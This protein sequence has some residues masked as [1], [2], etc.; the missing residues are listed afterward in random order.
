MRQYIA[1]ALTLGIVWCFVNGELSILNFIVGSFLG[2]LTMVSLNRLYSL[3]KDTSLRNIILRIPKLAT[4]I[5]ILM[6]EIIKASVLMAKIILG[7]RLD[8]K[9]GIMAVPIR[10]SKDASITAIANT[11]SLTPGTITIDVSDDMTELYVHFIDI[12]DPEELKASIRD[13]LERYVL[14]AFE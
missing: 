8:I 3:K 5:T 2:L 7:P 13:K 12:S 9:P 4:F 6:L 10:A 11:I 14:E 1:Y